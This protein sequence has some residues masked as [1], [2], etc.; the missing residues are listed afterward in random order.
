MRLPV[1]HD[2]DEYLIRLEQAGEL[3]RLRTPVSTMGE[4]EEI[5]SRLGTAVLFEHVQDSDFPVVTNLF[6]S[7]KRMAW[8]LGLD[9]LD[10]LRQRLGHLLDP[11]ATHSMSSM[12]ARA[13]E[14]MLALRSMQSARGKVTKASVQAVIQKDAID[15]RLLPFWSRT[16]DTDQVLRDVQ[17]IMPNGPENGQSLHI[18]DVY[19]R[20]AQ[21]L[22][23][24]INRPD[25]EPVAIVI[26][27]DPAQMW[28]GS[29]PMMKG[30]NM[31]LL[32]GWI[33]GRPVAFTRAVSHNLSVPANAEIVIEGWVERG[34]IRVSAI[35]HH[36][37]AM[38]A[39]IGPSE[40]AWMRKATE[41]MFLPFVRLIN[42]DIH[43]ISLQDNVVFV[44]IA[45]GV[46]GRKTMFGLW[47]LDM[48]AA[49]R[50]IVTLGS[51]VDVHDFDVMARHILTHWPSTDNRVV[52]DD[53]IGLDV[54]ALP[55]PKRDKGKAK[56]ETFSDADASGAGQTAWEVVVQAHLWNEHLLV[57]QATQDFDCEAY[58]SRI[59]DTL[60]E[61]SILIVDDTIDVQDAAQI[62][63]ALIASVTEHERDSA[64]W[65]VRSAAGFLFDTRCVHD[66]TDVS[67]VRAMVS[68]RW[69][70]YDFYADKS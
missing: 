34:I 31:Y 48:T 40:R 67:P 26:G 59:W 69:A 12:M 19:L 22:T 36:E 70:D 42:N 52:L 47:G 58:A 65:F 9:D 68:Q 6:G 51:D 53:R 43:E 63:R 24:D 16:T 7:A 61:C 66:D 4:I 56:R 32:A 37:D 62:V 38:V 11:S 17:I 23:I 21:T 33:R 54:T 25:R 50:M 5:A 8:A 14:F 13:G 27:G 29:V 49:S 44:S 57:L 64:S 45:P 35:T 30:L 46:D 41:R 2:L 3:V 10:E 28:C 20:D 60:P 18:G 15:L 55:S 39:M 1:Y